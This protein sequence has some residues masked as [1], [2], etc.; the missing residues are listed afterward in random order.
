MGGGGGL[1]GQMD[2]K[3]ST[4]PGLCNKV[5]SNVWEA[6]GGGHGERFDGNGKTK[7]RYT[8]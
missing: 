4:Q 5:L 8:H 6:G 2:Q 1:A 3:S 7:G